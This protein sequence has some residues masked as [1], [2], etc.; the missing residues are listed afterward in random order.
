MALGT[1]ALVLGNGL[2]DGIARQLT[3]NLVAVQTGHLQVVARPGDFEPQNSPFDA[4]SPL[5]LPGAQALARRL[6]A[7]PG[8]VRTAALLYGRGTAMAGGRSSM[9]SIIGIEPEREPELRAAHHLQAG[10]FLSATGRAGGEPEVFL[11][12][13]LA[14]KLR[15]GVGDAV[16]FVVQTPEGAVNSLDG[17]VVG[18]FQKGAPW[19]DHALYLSLGP[20]QDLFA[21]PGDAT[22]I[23]ITIEGGGQAAARQARPSI[24][25]LVRQTPL[26]GLD[27]DQR[28]LV[29]TFPEAGRFAF[30]IMEANRGAL[31]VLSSFLLAAAAVGIVNSMLMSVHERTREIG[32]IRA[33]GMRRSAVVRLFVL[34]GLVLGT[35]AAGL[36]ILAGGAAVLH[37]A[38]YGIP[39]NNTSLT[40]M[41]GGDRLFTVL[42]GASLARTA[43]T[44]VALSILAA[45][46]P[47]WV[48]S[49]LEPREALHH[50]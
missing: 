21:W 32:T 37:Y 15:V 34:E 41:A 11:A 2:A 39:M 43:A 23:K 33:L 16:S 20:A 27:P 36:G 13:P 31:L 5:R 25:A 38:A 44:I 48:A 1:A 3:A 46:Y 45:V 6:E 17:V 40:W 42:T 10:T 30:S 12:S 50:V 24:Q 8:V 18:V 14:Q 22:S 28:V 4:Y 26:P 29:E 7:L 35:A 49:R 9:A 19:Y 47:A